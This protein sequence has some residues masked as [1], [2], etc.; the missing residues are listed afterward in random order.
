[1]FDA[2]IEATLLQNFKIDK[3][4]TNN[5][6]DGRIKDFL[7]EADVKLRAKGI[8]LNYEDIGDLQLIVMYA[9]WRWTNRINGTGMNR[10]L[11]SNI[12]DRV[13]AEKMRGAINGT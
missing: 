3:G 5:A 13:L 2:N 1:M 7:K 4:F 10:M 9:E 8:T 11:K 6:F 12:N